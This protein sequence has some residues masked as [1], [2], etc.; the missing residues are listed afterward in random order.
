MGKRK[1]GLEEGLEKPVEPAKE[2]AG[3]INGVIRGA[4]PDGWQLWEDGPV[5]VGGVSWLRQH[6]LLV[7]VSEA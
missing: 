5:G 6:R 3:P 2:W 7:G 4:E 1:D